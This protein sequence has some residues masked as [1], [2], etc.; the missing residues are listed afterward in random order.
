MRIISLFFMMVSF[1]IF[2]KGERGGLYLG[3][4]GGSSTYN[5]DDYVSD[6]E[7]DFEEDYSSVDASSEAS[8][9]G[10]TKLF[11]GYR[12]GQYFGLEYN[13]GELGTLETSAD[14]STT[15]LGSTFSVEIDQTAVLTY[16]A[17]ELIGYIPL[18]QLDLMIR[19]GRVTLSSAISS[20]KDVNGTET[21]STTSAVD[22]G[23]RI[24]AGFQ[25]HIGMVSLRLDYDQLT[26][27]SDGNDLVVTSTGAGVSVNF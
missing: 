1:S 21:D 27:A 5:T 19:Y 16:T 3:G 18:N 13:T 26:I 23:T 22:S 2:A 24:G 11:V 25:F 17:F 8:S 9:A 4:L 12:F 14:A 10:Y 15:L 6:I 7:S 20:T